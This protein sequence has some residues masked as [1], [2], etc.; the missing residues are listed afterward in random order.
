MPTRRGIQILRPVTLAATFCIAGGPAMAAEGEGFYPGDLG[1]AIASVT[2]FVLLLMVLRKWAWKP[3]LHQLHRRE[4]DIAAALDKAQKREQEANELLELYR[5]R[6][7][8]AGID[9]EELLSQSRAEA[10]EVRRQ[11][12][13][14]AREEAR[15]SAERAREDVEQAKEKA[16]EDLRDATAHLATDIA[17]RVLRKGLTAEDHRRLLEES[18]AEL[19]K[20]TGKE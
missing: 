20:K 18:L 3:L 11:I 19:R 13:D 17:G 14:A 6:L 16:L 4:A 1:Q 10:A 12:V 5:T 2:V 8:A 15:L 9:A 7:E